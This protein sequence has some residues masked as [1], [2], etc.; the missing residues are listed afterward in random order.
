[1]NRYEN[2]PDGSSAPRACIFSAEERL[3]VHIAAGDVIEFEP[4]LADKEYPY[5]VCSIWGVIP[6]NELF[7][8]LASGDVS[9]V[10]SVFSPI[11]VPLMKDRLG[12]MRAMDADAAGAL[13]DR[14][15][16]EHR[17]ELIA[18]ARN[19]GEGGKPD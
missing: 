6:T 5:I 15:W 17:A 11:D 14:I 19:P 1:M 4:A 16:K 13:A 2:R 12:G 10:A 9:F 3:R 18:G 8:R 7:V